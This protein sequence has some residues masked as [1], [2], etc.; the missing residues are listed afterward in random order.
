M[1]AVVLQSTIF[2]LIL[3]GKYSVDKLINGFL[4]TDT[5]WLILVMI[6]VT[7]FVYRRCNRPCLFVWRQTAYKY[8]LRKMTDSK[9]AKV[10]NYGKKSR[11]IIKKIETHPIL[12]K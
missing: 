9:E 11:L 12:N 2:V 3:R 1:N 5:Y 10:S 8:A 7:V 4:S 6:L